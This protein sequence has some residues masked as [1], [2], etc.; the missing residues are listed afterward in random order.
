MALE[1]VRQPRDRGPDGGRGAPAVAERTPAR[2]R[3]PIDLPGVGLASGGL[4]ALVY[5]FS[6]A[7]TTSWTDPVTIIALGLSAVLLI[8]FITFE[9]R[10]EHPLLPLHIV[11]DRSRGGAYATIALAD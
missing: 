10:V 6:N 9:R 5:G 11:W 7:E 8:G 1:S 2:P 4:F 3:A